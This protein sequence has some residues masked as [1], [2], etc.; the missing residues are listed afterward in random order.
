MTWSHRL[1]TGNC[2]ALRAGVAR[3]LIVSALVLA[4]APGVAAEPFSLGGH[5][6]GERLDS[7]LADSRF[8]CNGLAGCFLYEV[9]TYRE[10]DHGMFR[11]V[12][13]EGLTLYFTGE[14]LSGIEASF[15]EPAFQRMLTTLRE[16]YGEGEVVADDA[17]PENSVHIWRSGSRLL[18]IERLLRPNRSSIIVA[19]RHL[20]SELTR[21]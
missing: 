12:P 8:D 5:K 7:V 3:A 18:R 14:R 16:E 4:T 2:D 10:A 19:E 11:N 17:A 15:D 1:F 6:L 9:C 20:L 21:R 13:I